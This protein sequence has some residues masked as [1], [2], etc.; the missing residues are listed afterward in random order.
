MLT[1]ADSAARA[2]DVL[3]VKPFTL[4]GCLQEVLTWLILL[5]YY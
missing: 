1:A 5:D 4:R 2:S 3:V